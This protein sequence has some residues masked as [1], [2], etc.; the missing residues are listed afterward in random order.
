MTTQVPH[1]PLRE[2]HG[3]GLLQTLPALPRGMTAQ[4]ARCSTVL[5]RTTIHGLDQ[6][7]ALVIAAL[8][9]LIVTST[10]TMMSVQTA[11]IQHSAYLLSGP[12]EL[13]RRDMALLAAVVVFVTLVAPFARLAGLLYVLIR[14][15]ES[16]PPDH[17]VRLFALTERL[18]PWAMVEVF[19]FGVF[20]AYVKLNDLVTITLDPGVYALLVLTFVMI[21]AD[22][23]IDR[24]A[25]WE[26]IGGGASGAR[27]LVARTCSTEFVGCE[28]CGLVTALRAGSRRCPRCASR[29]HHRKPDSL[30]RTWAL[31]IAAAV[32]YVPANYF[33][34]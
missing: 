13:V 26:R 20:V 22:T 12:S 15:R 31:V 11:G 7:T 16:A 10:T 29:L 3:C 33:P 9:L 2:C 8:V 28:L 17:L 5:Q 32:M 1:P 18:R 19:V 30:A 23:A 27:A 6:T 34:V 14:L 21:W 4:C 24:E 25:I